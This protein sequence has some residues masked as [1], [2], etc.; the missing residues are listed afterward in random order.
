[1]KLDKIMK[2]IETLLEQNKKLLKAI[3]SVEAYGKNLS[4][5]EEDYS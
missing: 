1:M 4:N 2:S 5:N 3:L